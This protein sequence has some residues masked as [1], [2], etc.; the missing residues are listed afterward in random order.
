[1]NRCSIRFVLFLGV[2]LAWLGTCT[3]CHAHGD[4]CETFGG[5]CSDDNPAD[6]DSTILG[7]PIA[8]DD[9]NAANQY[10]LE[11]GQWP[12]PGGK[13]TPITLT[14][15]FQN[16]FDGSMHGP[17]ATPGYNGVFQPNGPPLPN[18]LIRHSIEQALGLWASV[19]PINYVEVPD[20][21]AGHGQIRFRH[22]Y[23][24]GTDPPDPQDPIA[25]AQAYFPDSGGDV[26][27]DVEFDD[28]DPWQAVGT[29]HIP[30]LLGAATHEIGHTL[31]LAHT[32]VEGAVM[33][34]IFHR[35]NGLGT[36]FLTPVD[37]AGVQAIYG[38]GHGSVTPLPVPEP[39]A[40]AML[41][42][43]ITVL[44]AAGWRRKPRSKQE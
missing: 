24:N 18:D 15:S 27:G 33:Y 42:E 3:I 5:V 21:A 35:F 37:I 22:I 8:A 26:A 43:A 34:W 11:G 10:V 40:E 4:E 14:Y 28:S 32:P 9:P 41:I 19:A 16:M 36:G 7:Q 12:Q 17:G 29:T 30:D 39:A 44:F 38:A 20:N 25:K 23:I 31:G 1:M 2:L 13:G 6:G